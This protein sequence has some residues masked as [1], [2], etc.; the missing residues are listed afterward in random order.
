MPRI[1]STLAVSQSPF[2]LVLISWLNT[3][4]LANIPDI[5]VTIEVFQFPI[6][7]LNTEAP[8][9]ILCIFSTFSVF[10]FPISW[11]KLEAP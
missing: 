11:L 8:V 2:A 1:F 4:A 10:Q 3:E 7:W 6:S 9:N 5:L